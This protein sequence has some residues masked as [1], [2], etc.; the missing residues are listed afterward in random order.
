MRRSSSGNSYG[1]LTR[2][3]FERT[4]HLSDSAF[5]G[6]IRLATISAS[7]DS[8]GAIEE[9]LALI[10]L[11]NSK[12]KAKRIFAELTTER[13]GFRQAL[14]RDGAGWRINEEILAFG[15]D[16]TSWCDAESDKVL[17]RD[18]ARCRYC[19]LRLEENEVTFDHVFPR[20]R[21]GSDKPDN[22]VVACMPC[23][24]KKS[25]RTPAEAEMPLMV[26]P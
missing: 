3:V 15:R 23:N 21:G 9:K 14:I 5:R 25:D 17:E 4:L 20:S 11:S 24:L 8:A 1:K 19:A 22:L 2:G 18:G 6:L 16:G 7:W 13:V 10:L 26:L 12:K